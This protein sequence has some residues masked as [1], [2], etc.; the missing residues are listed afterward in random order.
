MSHEVEFF[1]FP[2]WLCLT[3]YINFLLLTLLVCNGI[4]ILSDHPRLL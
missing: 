2:F 1:G 4:Q 3:H